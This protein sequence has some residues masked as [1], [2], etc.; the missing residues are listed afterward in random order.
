MIN[1]YLE[2]LSEESNIVYFI[3]TNFICACLIFI[4]VFICD[5]IIEYMDLKQEVKEM[6]KKIT[7]LEKRKKGNEF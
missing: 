4:F 3:L 5:Q 2:W 1:I 7:E 6:S